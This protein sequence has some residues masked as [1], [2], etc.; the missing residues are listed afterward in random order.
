MVRTVIFLMTWERW[1]LE[2]LVDLLP[3]RLQCRLVPQCPRCLLL[4]LLLPLSTKVPFPSASHFASLFKSQMT[5]NYWQN[6]SIRVFGVF[7]LFLSLLFSL[8]FPLSPLNSSHPLLSVLFSLLL[9]SLSSPCSLYSSHNY[10]LQ[11]EPRRRRG[12]AS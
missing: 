10:F 1:D 9:S 12:N 7:L 4:L 3:F 6:L 2:I 11:S 5:L 8:S